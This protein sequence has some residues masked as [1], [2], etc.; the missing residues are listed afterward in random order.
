MEEIWK[1]IKGYEGHY[2]VSNLGNVKSFKYG[3]ET[4]LKRRL[5]DRGYDTAMLYDKGKQKCFKIHRLVAQAFIPNLENK[6][7]VNHIDGNKL[8]NS[9][10]NLEWCTHKENITH[11]FKTGL[12]LQSLSLKVRDEKGR[13]TN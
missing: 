11:G 10:D 2:K 6:S 12:F 13:F 3:K 1:D 9:V 7:E 8:N 4:L 5:T